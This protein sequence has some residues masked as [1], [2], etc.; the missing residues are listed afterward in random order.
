VFR[1]P[2]KAE[3]ER[4]RSRQ[5]S[6]AAAAGRLEHYILRILRDRDGRPLKGANIT[7]SSRR[8]EALVIVDPEL[9]PAG[10]KRVTTVTDIPKDPIKRALKAGEQV[11]GVALEQHEYL[12]RK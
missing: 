6:A 5:Q 8:S 11:P 3:I 12:V 7:L 1:L 9:V 4:L 2:Q 10:W